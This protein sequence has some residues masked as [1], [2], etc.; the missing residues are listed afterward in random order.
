MTLSISMRPNLR[1]ISYRRMP[2]RNYIVDPSLGLL[3]S[4][5]QYTPCQRGRMGAVST[6]CVDNKLSKCNEYP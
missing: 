2:H 3:V 1:A 5:H 6:K 4:L